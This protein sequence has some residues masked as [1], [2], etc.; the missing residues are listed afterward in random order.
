MPK[1]SPNDSA[2]SRRS[3]RLA[4]LKAST[5]QAPPPEPEF[6][7]ES[8]LESESEPEDASLPM[9]K[10]KWR[11]STIDP[12]RMI[13][14]S[15]IRPLYRLNPEKDLD[16]LVSTKERRVSSIGQHLKTAHRYKE[17]EV[18]RV[19]WRK[20]GGPKGFEAHLKKLRERYEKSY[21]NGKGFRVPAAYHP[22]AQALVAAA[23]SDVWVSRAH[24]DKWLWHVCNLHIHTAGR[25]GRK[26]ERLKCAL[27]SLPVYPPRTAPPSKLSSSFQT[28][29]AL[30]S[31]APEIG[32]DG[33]PVKNEHNVI[34]E[35]IAFPSDYGWYWSPAYLTKLYQALMA[36]IEE[37]GLGPDGWEAARWLVYDQ[38][39]RGWE[40]IEIGEETARDLAFGWLQPRLPDGE[41]PK[42]RF[43]I[44]DESKPPPIWIKYN[45]LLPI[46]E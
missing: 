35:D 37:H 24:G 27:R 38:Y 5:S 7:P 43:G 46:G 16:G 1:A 9:D 44:S 17:I 26:I 41:Y 14:K 8:D 45:A 32:M 34:M 21:P 15:D 19:A 42:L 22:D 13:L 2:L 25:S 18:E 31:E 33:T 29:K 23:R 20:N 10:S 3:T 4:N 40:G 39:S 36:I 28:L 12:S 30:L 11:A 6:E